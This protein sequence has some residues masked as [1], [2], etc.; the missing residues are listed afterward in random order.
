[1][2]EKALI[3]GAID[4]DDEVIFDGIR[5]WAQANATPECPYDD[6]ILEM[7]PPKVLFST[8]IRQRVLS[9][10]RLGFIPSSW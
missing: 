7:M 4:A 6:L 3:A 10:P 8:R 5:R 2:L 9:A 1:M